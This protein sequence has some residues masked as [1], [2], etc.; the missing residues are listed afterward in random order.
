MRASS[1]SL[2]RPLL[3]HRGSTGAARDLDA[4]LLR[5]APPALTR[6]PRD[7]RCGRGT[8]M[9]ASSASLL[10][11]LLGHRGSTGA[12]RDL[13][14]GLLRF[15]P[16]ALTRPPLLDRRGAG[17]RCGPPPLRSSGSYSAAAGRPAR[18]R[19][20]DAGLLRFAPPALTRPPRVDRRSQPGRMTR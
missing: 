15:A 4:G 5:F 10:R 2:L 12:A 8:S 11:P 16:P 6:P 17:P 18:A 7:D 1:A 14:A 13:D 19:D 20:L 9:R 3:G